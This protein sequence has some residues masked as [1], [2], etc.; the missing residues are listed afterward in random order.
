MSTNEGMAL[1]GLGLFLVILVGFAILFSLVII[2]IN[3]VGM[4]KLF[5]KAGEDGWKAII[6]IY[7]TLIMSKLACGN[8]KLG[9][10]SLCLTAGYFLIMCVTN[11]INAIATSGDGSLA[12]LSLI[13]L[14]LSLVGIALSLGMAVIGGY[15]HY[16][17]TKSYG[18]DTV[19]CVLSIFFSP[20][21]FLIIGFD[22][23]AKYI[24]PQNT[25]KW[26]E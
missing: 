23:N 10:A 1:A 6:P 3:F 5:E 8:F 14:P 18:K 22:K 11:T 17:F 21:I 12:I 13:S 19:W 4:W 20:I 2:V 15:F 25:L 26:F 9:I 24:G 7:N 16:I